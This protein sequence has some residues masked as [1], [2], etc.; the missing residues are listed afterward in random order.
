M[1]SVTIGLDVNE[2]REFTTIAVAEREEREATNGRSE[3]HH[4]VRHLERLSEGSYPDG[5]ARVAEI[6]NG[7]PRPTGRYRHLPRLFL[8]VNVTNVGTPVLDVLR[9]AGVQA[10]L[11]SALLTHGQERD[12]DEKDREVRLGRAWLVTRLEALLKTGRLHLPE[13]AAAE[14]LAQELLDYENGDDRSGS[15]VTA[16]GLAVQ[17]DQRGARPHKIIRF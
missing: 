17:V 13:T 7:V 15:L 6:V 16:L 8:Y 5:P 14:A 9:H 12:E 2:K 1:G 11:M 4:V 3:V 10:H